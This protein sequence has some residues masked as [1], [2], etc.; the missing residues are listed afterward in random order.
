MI[1]KI[2]ASLQQQELIAAISTKASKLGGMTYEL[3]VSIV[4]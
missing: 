3:R 1:K 4:M 2:A